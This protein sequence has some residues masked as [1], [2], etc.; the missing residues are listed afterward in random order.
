MLMARIPTKWQIQF[1]FVS[2]LVCNP[3]MAPGT[4]GLKANS[5]RHV[6]R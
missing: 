5:R 3:D 2:L 6:R 1:L 4:S